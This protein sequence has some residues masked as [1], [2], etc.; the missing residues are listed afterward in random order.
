MH[1]YL[2][3]V[4]AIPLGRLTSESGQYV[5]AHQKDSILVKVIS[6]LHF[7]QSLES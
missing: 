4:S 1:D 3:Q 6:L 5:Q 2:L 7:L